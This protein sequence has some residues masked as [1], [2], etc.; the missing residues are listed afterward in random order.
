[1]VAKRK[2]LHLSKSRYLAGQQCEKRLWL[3]VHRRGL[4]TPPDAAQQAR[5][6]KGSEIG[7][8]ARAIYPGGVLIRESHFQHTAACERTRRLLSDA[9]VPFLFEAAFEYRAVRVRADVLERLE[10]ER[11]RLIEVKSSSK[12]KDEHLDDLAI[13]RFVL[14]GAGLAVA[15]AGLLHVDRDYLLDPG[16]IDWPRFFHLEDLTD[17]VQ[18]R[19][20]AVAE[21]VEAMH[22][23][24]AAK[25]APA[26]GPG[27]HCAKPYDCAFW[28]HCT[29]SKPA[30]WVFYLPGEGAQFRR[31]EK[32]G[33]ER[34]ADIPDDWP[35]S[36]KAGRARNALR[37]GA[38]YISADL[39]KALSNSGPP[40]YYLDFESLNPG[41]P[42]YVGTR[43]YEQVPFQWSLHHQDGR[44]KVTQRG[45]LANGSAD[46]RRPVAQ[47]LLAALEEK[48]DPILVYTAFESRL[49]SALAEWLPDLALRL[50]A[51]QER[52]CDLHRIVR[53]HVYHADFAGSF[54][55]K[56]VAPALVAGFSYD[57]LEGVAGGSD[58]ALAFEQ[59]ASG[60]V[61]GA[62]AARSRS[63]LEAY[64][65]RDT[66]ALLEL[67]RALREVS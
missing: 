7:E 6:A 12:V 63:A 19:Q 20:T 2:S 11:W 35:L 4:A 22:R 66:E 1:M 18:A 25:K 44:G 28:E 56:Q 31:L 65:A 32:A 41:V 36:E 61:R 30:D 37:S 3:E 13:Q 27:P 5:F 67:H 21:R 51:L 47:S 55:I 39:G 60:A 29:R 48:S 53:E 59:L 40:A 49:I 8:R 62:E 17:R 34:I 45:F 24:L 9:K 15:Q 64:C 46:P 42:L 33:I 16:G 54:S 52:L 57:G 38:P 26:I 23:T 43:P 50:R 10:N 58:A 14:E